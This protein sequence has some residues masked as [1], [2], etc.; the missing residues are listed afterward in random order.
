MAEILEVR[1]IGEAEVDRAGLVLRH[2][3][4]QIYPPGIAGEYIDEVAHVKG[5]MDNAVVLVAL[6]DGQVVGCVSLVLEESSPLAEGL[7]AGE[8]GIRMLGV[9]PEVHRQGVGRALVE[10]CLRRARAAHKVAAVLHTD[11]R[12][13]AA[14]LLYER[15]GFLRLPER[16]VNFPGVELIC[17]R[18]ALLDDPSGLSSWAT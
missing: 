2:A 9:T 14:Q 5:R 6:L 4:Q 12:M 1:P 11:T 17:Y 7:R 15:Q 13:H 18:R 16:D 10:E 3:Y 8:A